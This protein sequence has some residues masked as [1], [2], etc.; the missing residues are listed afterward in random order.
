MDSTFLKN[1]QAEYNRLNSEQREAVDTIEGPVMVIAGA[2]TGKTQTIALRIGKILSDTQ[3]NPNNILCLT[4]TESAALNMRQRLISLIGPTAYSVRICTFHAFC[5]SVIQD[6]PEHF[7]YSKR[8]ATSLD[9]VKLIQTIRSLIDD[10]PSGSP[11]RNF[12]FS[13]FFQKDIIRAIQNLKKENISAAHFSELIKYSADFVN[14]SQSCLEKL[15]AIR[16][17]AKTGTDI[18]NIIKNLSQNSKL[19]PLYQARLQLFLTL[20]HQNNLSPSDLKKNIRD[21]IDQ[22]QNQLPKLLDLLTIYQGYEKALLDNSLFDYDDMILWVINAFKKVPALLVEYQ[23]TYQYLLV[24]E[25]QDTNASQYEILNLLTSSES[26]PNLFVVGDDDQSIFRFQ[27]ASIE[28]IYTFYQKYKD[29]LKIVILKNNYRSHR[30]ILEVSDNVIKSNLNRITQFIGNLDKSLIATKTFD[31]DPINLTVAETDTDEVITVAQKIKNLITA[32][33][34]PREI[35]VLYRNN[36]DISEFLP[37]F[38]KQGIKF[39]ISDSIDILKTPKIQ[40]LLT[41]LKFIVDSSDVDSLGKILS[42]D[43]IGLNALELYHLFHY[44][45]KNELD[46]TTLL[47]SHDTLKNILPALSPKAIRRLQRFIKKVAK[48][49]KASKNLPLSMVFDQ[50]IRHFGYLKYVLKHRQLD[51]LKQ[52]NT[53]HTLIR[54]RL[55]TEDS[56]DL[57]KFVA[58]INLLLENQI[59]L[60][61]QPLI[62]DQDVSIRLMTVHKAKGLEFEHVFLIRCLTGKWDGAFT[63]N[64]IKL[65]LGIV[66]TDINQIAVDSDLEEDRRLFYVAL[67][68]AKNQIYLSYSRL[69]SSGR[70]QLPTVFLSEID[71]KLIEK[72][73]PDSAS[74]TTNLLSL[75]PPKMPSLKSVNLR[76]YLQN[77][78]STSYRFNITHLNSYLKCPLCFFFKT[79]LRLPS[80]KTKSLSF[81]TS[82]HGALAYLYEVLKKDNHLIPLDKFLSVFEAN[83]QREHLKTSDF[84]AIASHGRAILTDYYTHYQTEFNGRCFTEHDF[85]FYNIRLDNIPLTGKIDKMDIVDPKTVSVVDFKTG[86]PDTKYQELS[87]DGDYFRQLVFYKILCQNAHGFPYKVNAGTID[88]IEK[89]KSGQFKRANFDLSADDVSKLTIL[90]KEVFQ[91]IQNL[92]FTPNLDCR[93]PDHLHYLYNKYFA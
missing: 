53:L 18:E 42:F 66:K 16:A 1:F 43:F 60:N 17:T 14:E 38:T 39:L 63:R 70:E 28:N 85:R 21:F 84:K 30:L 26:S 32:G 20:Y 77:Y 83:L 87:K 92:E 6:H 47:S 27:G 22:T 82:V 86:N 49:K 31:P 19:H 88:F 11:L 72:H 15:I 45:S 2:G 41:L 29:I 64:L 56:Y 5:N 37:V 44:Q 46:L 79:I 59:S 33:T 61:T 13:Y 73:L 68:R 12:N 34:S 91:K 50:I 7:L 80:A 40:Q 78:L 76:S 35:A 48:I 52:L 93:N 25:F 9:D 62:A 24:D 67:T 23:E 69:N 55:Q 75:Y 36:A 57:S 89:S 10:L 54:S 90:I 65:P 3:V 51:V 58:E 74:E 8:E 71:P 4:F 81:G